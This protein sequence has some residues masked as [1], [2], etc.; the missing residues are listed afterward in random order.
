MI[1]EFSQKTI[2]STTF[3][4]PIQI[5]TKMIGLWI[6]STLRI[7]QI[8][9]TGREEIPLQQQE[10]HFLTTMNWSNSTTFTNCSNLSIKKL[11]TWPNNC[12]QKIVYQSRSWMT[13]N[14]SVTKELLQ[15]PNTL[16]Y[17][18]K[19][20]TKATKT[21]SPSWATRLWCSNM[22]K[23]KHKPLYLLTVSRFVMIRATLS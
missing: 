19:R 7:S 17:S 16:K 6:I 5:T 11:R 10:A 13:S 22:T 9:L 14:M 21:Q 20:D 1:S 15:S 18:K 2:Q 8:I 3:I 12:L 4:K 23:D